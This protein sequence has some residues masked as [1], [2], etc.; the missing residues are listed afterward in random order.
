MITSG[1][2]AAFIIGAYAGVGV[3]VLAV[4][5]YVAWDA[6]RVRARLA[7]LDRAGI[8][9]RSAGTSQ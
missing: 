6:H 5:G 7:A 1:A 4:I 3:L 2:H 8:R 9:R